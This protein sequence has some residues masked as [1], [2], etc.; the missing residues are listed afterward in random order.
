M[1]DAL[2]GPKAD[3]SP[4]DNGEPDRRERNLA[5]PALVLDAAGLLEDGTAAA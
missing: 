2:A 4:L 5:V 1:A 3:E